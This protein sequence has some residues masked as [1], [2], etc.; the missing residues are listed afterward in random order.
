MS[1]PATGTLTIPAKIIVWLVWFFSFFCLA[2][3]R[4]PVIHAA[5][6]DD[7]R[8]IVSHIST[9]PSDPAAPTHIWAVLI[10]AFLVGAQ[11]EGWLLSA[12]T[13]CR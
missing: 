3:G 1:D 4:V 7:G 11:V 8:V 5:C 12:L 9:E 10:V 6:R 13:P 2:C